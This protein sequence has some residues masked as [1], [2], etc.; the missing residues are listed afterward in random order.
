MFRPPVPARDDVILYELLVTPRGA[1]EPMPVGTARFT[2][3]RVDIE[4]PENIKASLEDELARPFVDRV[5]PDERPAGYRRSNRAAVDFLVPGMP[6]HFRARMRGLW[7]SYPDGSVVTARAAEYQ[8]PA[9]QLPSRRELAEPVATDAAV[10]AETL[11]RNAATL[12]SALVQAHPP[13]PG[14]RPADEVVPV[15]RTDCGWIH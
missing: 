10:R 4:A 12:G 2:A 13:A 11:E 5:Q 9:Q 7:L 6:E 15:G 8:P 1:R 14:V 3:G